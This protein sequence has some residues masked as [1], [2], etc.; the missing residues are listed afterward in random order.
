MKKILI[1]G[2]SGFI[3][4]SLAEYFTGKYDVHAPA[5]AILDLK[6][7]EA[8]RQYLEKH[9]FDAVIHSANM[10]DVTY[11]L[12]PHDILDGN[13]RMFYHLEICSRL[14]GKMIYFGSGAEYD[15][16]NYKPLMEEE[17]FGRHIPADPYGFSK[18]TMHRI[19]EQGRNLYN[20]I[21]FGVYGRYEQ[22]QRRFISNNIC[23]SI[24]GKPMTLNKN[25]KLDYLY[26]E[27]LCKIVEWFLE[28][29]PRHKCY[30]VCTG[31][32]VDLLTL[33]REINEVTELGREILIYEEGWKP[34]YSGNN[35][36]LLE[37]IGDFAFY[38]R[39]TAIADMVKYYREQKEMLLQNEC[40]RK[41]GGKCV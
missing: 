7:A 34:E 8:V 21:L 23:K 15:M 25:A 22:F 29:T 13:L 10:N 3:G 5:H 36:R 35:A 12:S 33:A 11:R 4:R 14:Y 2:A 17:Y 37:E 18:Y 38:D 9:R 28:H 31:R 19:A 41:V 20:L 16:Q 39:K 32:A 24:L 6:D 27:D 1:T 30:N 26:I 40:F